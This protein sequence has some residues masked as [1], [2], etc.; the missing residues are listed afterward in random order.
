MSHGCGPGTRKVCCLVVLLGVFHLKSGGCCGS[1][2]GM[3]QGRVQM[4]LMTF[5]HGQRGSPL[6]VGCGTPARKNGTCLICENGTCNI[7]NSCHQSHHILSV[8]YC[9]M[10][11]E[12]IVC[13]CRSRLPGLTNLLLSHSTHRGICLPVW[14]A[15]GLVLRGRGPGLSSAAGGG[16]DSARTEQGVTCA[17]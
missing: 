1:E 12:N 9:D 17:G 11:G 16:V 10:Y 15:L 4:T 3:S 6:G 7:S 14:L 8:T 13:S 2:D 5:S